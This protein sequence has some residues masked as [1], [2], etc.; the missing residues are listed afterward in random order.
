MSFTGEIPK[1]GSLSIQENEMPRSIRHA[2]LGDE[3]PYCEKVIDPFCTG[4]S[5]YFEYDCNHP[6]TCWF[7]GYDDPKNDDPREEE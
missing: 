3:C 7:D 6:E 4:D 2:A 1:R 5:G